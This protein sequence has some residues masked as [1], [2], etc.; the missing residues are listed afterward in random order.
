[1]S[2]DLQACGIMYMF[3]V[4]ALPAIALGI[5]HMTKIY[6]N[7]FVD[8]GTRSFDAERV[9]VSLTAL[10]IAW[11]VP[12]AYFG[13]MYEKQTCQWFWLF[14]VYFGC[15]ASFYLVLGFMLLVVLWKKRAGVSASARAELHAGA[16]S[17]SQEPDDTM[18]MTDLRRQDGDDDEMD[19]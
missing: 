16:T 5:R 17:T 10:H 4:A 3:C 2:S 6:P 13:D 7:M 12:V 9:L 15:A 14:W 19:A 8:A 18:E 1:M 11:S